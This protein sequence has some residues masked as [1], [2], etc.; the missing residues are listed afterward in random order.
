MP[1]RGSG[2]SRTYRTEECLEW[3]FQQRL[4]RAGKPP[5]GEEGEGVPNKDV[6]EARRKA[7]KAELEELKVRERRGELVP[8]SEVADL[9]ED[10]AVR[11]RQRLVDLP[12]R[13]LKEIAAEEELAAIREIRMQAVRETLEELQDLDIVGEEKI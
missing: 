13:R 8:S 1:S 3:R 7:A 11:I 12:G 2:P 4:E 10:V 6:S 5:G 9:V